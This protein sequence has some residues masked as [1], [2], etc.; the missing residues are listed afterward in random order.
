[1]IPLRGFVVLI[2]C[3]NGLYGLHLVDSASL[4][5]NSLQKQ[6]QEANSVV[7]QEDPDKA[8]LSSDVVKQ[9]MWKR[10]TS[11]GYMT[12]IKL[13]LVHFVEKLGTTDSY[14]ILPDVSIQRHNVSESRADKAKPGDLEHLDEYLASKLSQYLGSLSLSIR[15]LDKSTL[16]GMRRFGE[17]AFSGREMRDSEQPLPVKSTDEKGGKKNK[18]NYP[19]M[20]AGVVS[21]GTLLVLGMKTIAALAGKALIASMLSLLLT[22]LSLFKGHGGG[23]GHAE[24][25]STTYEIITKPVVTHAHS[26]DVHHEAQGPE[27][28]YAYRRSMELDHVLKP[29]RES[30][31]NVEHVIYRIHAP[32]R[33]P[34]YIP[35][36]P[37]SG[38]KR[39]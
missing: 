38:K 36:D 25:K 1:M 29:L 15:V 30:T 3:V 32:E 21:G 37:A 26:T 31:D 33:T 18:Y 2:F 11:K 4:A 14:Q 39:R 20:M 24:H 13:A 9:I 19:L 16:D 23:G 12:C 8:N 7:P 6:D 22:G 28:G 5:N 27:G 35:I 17:V 10:C 34:V